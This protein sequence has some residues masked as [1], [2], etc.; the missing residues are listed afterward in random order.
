MQ[1]ADSQ[2]HFPSAFNKGITAYMVI[3][4]AKKAFFFFYELNR[5][6][7]LKHYMMVW[8]LDIVTAE[9]LASLLPIETISKR[10]IISRPLEITSVVIVYLYLF[11]Q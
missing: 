9:S 6:L 10:T 2:R 5:K 3:Y 8:T 7:E 4:G 1:S 11:G